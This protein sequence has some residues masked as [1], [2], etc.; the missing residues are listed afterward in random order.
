MRFPNIVA[1]LSLLLAI[2]SAKN[3]TKFPEGIFGRWLPVEPPKSILGPLAYEFLTFHDAGFSAFRHNETNDVWF[4]VLWGQVFHTRGN[5][6]QY[7]FGELGVLMEQSPFE[8]DSVDDTHITYCWRSTMRRMPT[9]ATGCS[10]CQCAKITLELTGKDSLEFT[11]W[12]SPP[13]VHAHLVMKRH[14]P[15]PTILAIL[16]TMDL[17]YDQCDF[18]D[19]WGPNLPNIST[20]ESTAVTTPKFRGCAR[21]LLEKVKTHEELS[22]FYEQYMG[23]LE[24]P[25]PHV[26]V[27]EANCHQLN[28]FNRVMND[29]RPILHKLDIPDVRLQFQDPQRPCDPCNVSYSVSAEIDEDE[30]IALGF[31]GQSWEGKFPTPPERPYRPCYFGMCM[32]DYDNFTSDRIAVGYAS[33]SVGSCVREMIARNQIGTPEDAGFKILKET[34][35]ERKRNRTIV[36]FTISQNWPS[37]KPIDGWFRIMWAIGKVIGDN[38]GCD[39]M[40]TY[41][42]IKRGMSPLNWLGVLGSTPCEYD[43]YELPLK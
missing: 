12:Q 22:T 6:M 27:G 42:E 25:K 8:V 5:Q 3:V 9:H 24:A 29:V 41:H 2:A 18:R 37:A 32:N 31:K 14:G 38:Q 13:V 15:P 39:A 19:K 21:G 16:S 11:F 40:L 43:P 30:Y 35:V 23:G 28:G 33:S 10:G 1:T 4:T 20:E 7:C 36:R 34:S 17:P 26:Q